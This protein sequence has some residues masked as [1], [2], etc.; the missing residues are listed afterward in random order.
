MCVTIL[1]CNY[2]FKDMGTWEYRRGGEWKLWI[3]RCNRFWRPCSDSNSGQ[4]VGE[5]GGWAVDAIAS[6]SRFLNI[7]FLVRVNPD[8][9]TLGCW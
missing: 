5:P 2:T 4:A 7:D 8:V 3:G 1:F 6:S 9:G